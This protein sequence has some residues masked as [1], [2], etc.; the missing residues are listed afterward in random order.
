MLHKHVILM[1]AIKTAKTYVEIG[2]GLEAF[3][4]RFPIEEIPYMLMSAIGASPT[5]LQRY[6]EGKG[7]V[8]SFN[9]LLIKNILAYRQV[10]TTRM[11]EELEAMK[12]DK[13]V[14]KNRPAILAVSDGEII[15]AFDPAVEETYENH[16]D[17]LYTDYEFF[18]PMWG[19]RKIRNIE[20]NDADVK[21]AYKMAQIH[22]E[23]RRHNHISITDDTHDLNIFMSR[24]LFCFFAED[25]GIFEKDL[26]TNAINNTTRTDGTD[27]QEFFDGAFRTMD[28]NLRIGVNSRW[29]QFPY[30]NGG[31][32]SKKIQ[33]PKMN[34][35]IRKLVLDCGA[36]NW[37]KINPDIFGSMIQAVVTP[38]LRSGL[39]IHYTSVS[40]IK[41][42]INPLFLDELYGEY[43]ELERKQ[44]EQDSLF[45]KSAV[46]RGS[47]YDSC[48]S[49]V[50]KCQRLLKR[51]SRMKF[52]DPAC[53]SGNFLIISYKELRLLEMKVLKLMQRMTPD[54]QMQFIDGSII[55]I[56]QF[57]GLE[58]N[59]FTCETAILSL[60]LAEHQMN[61]LFM[62][63][64]G[65]NIKALPLKSNNNFHCGNACRVDWN[66]VCPHKADEEVYVMGNPPYL[67]SSLQEES[68]KADMGVVFKGIDGWKN[69]DYITCWFYLGTL[70]IKGTRGKL[71]F[72]ST[73]SITQGE[74]VVLLWPHIF[75]N[76]VC[77]S[78]A[79]I[80]FK[81]TNNAKYNAGVTCVIIG[82]ETIDNHKDSDLYKSDGT[83]ITLKSI[84]PYLFEFSS[85]TIVRKQSHSFFDVSPMDY[86][87][88]A[89]DGGHLILDVYS[90][91]KLL[92]TFP[93][94]SVFI[95]R[96]VG[97]DDFIN[98]EE[99]FCLWIED[100]D[101]EFAKRIPEIDRRIEAVRAMRLAS[102][103][104]AT[105]KDADRAHQLA[106]R[107]YNE[108]KCILVPRVSSENRDY[109][110][111]GYL[112]EGT[113]VADSAFA[114]YNAPEWLFGILTS[115]MHMAW[116]RAIGG[117]L[118][119][120]YRYSAGLCYNPFP[121]PK[122]TPAQKQEIEDAA[123]EVLGARE[124]HI[125]KTLAE[126]YDPETMPADLREAHHQ[127]D[128]I[129]DRCYRERPFADENER[130]ELLLKLYDKMTKH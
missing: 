97:S 4:G 74:Q 85:D 39:G 24:L 6:R 35:R 56:N 81:W 90:K 111:I 113:V 99:R 46:G 70:F 58:I 40:N 17:N 54:I 33:I 55:S 28:M 104:A 59:D 7:T 105:R 94:A 37:G 45:D 118:K 124:A 117:R 1:A 83:I 60:W 38:E 63:D 73:N 32:F 98:N 9:G 21:A 43:R 128:L 119:T 126:L 88:K 120:D 75:Q 44:K 106:E 107:R 127:L 51:M 69:L 92:D 22:D 79:Y 68:H 61:S 8:A 102:K 122:L 82:L 84:S 125:G 115:A 42:V 91:N 36:L 52:F 101:L 129:V 18:S 41:K 13:W 96:Y 109:I 78:F 23:I 62:K 87:S 64:F 19:V 110:P 49:L 66:K 114:I 29:A 116:V 76:E 72:V 26:F 20:E 11:N 77:I 25:T 71:A 65:V 123:W 100:E 80:S 31:L 10:R 34:A 15:K 53:G 5:I 112:A 95:K 16:L 14:V 30:V 57:Y 12:R 48:T 86:G 50:R 93:E 47:Y 27:L 108:S 67:G 89:T 2:L 103:K 121:F 3:K 130:L